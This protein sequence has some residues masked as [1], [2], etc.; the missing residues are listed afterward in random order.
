MTRGYR[1]GHQKN[2]TGYRA[3][4]HTNVKL[5]MNRV[6]PPKYPCMMKPAIMHLISDIPEPAAYRA[7]VLT[8]DAE[9][10]ENIV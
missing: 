1:R 8:K 7:K 6:Q 4:H 9:I 3:M 10:K 2:N 5:L